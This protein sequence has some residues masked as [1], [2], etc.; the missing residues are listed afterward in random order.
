[1]AFHVLDTIFPESRSKLYAPL[2]ATSWIRKGHSQLDENLPS[3]LLVSLLILQTMSPFWKLLDRLVVRNL[4]AASQILL[5]SRSSFTKSSLT[6]RL[7]SLR[8]RSNIFLRKVGS[9]TSTGI[10]ASVPYIRLYGV[11]CVVVWGVHLYAHM[12]N[13]IFLRYKYEKVVYV[14]MLIRY[15]LFFFYFII[16]GYNYGCYSSQHNPPNY[17]FH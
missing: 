11:S 10:I 12:K 5:L 9:P 14:Y 1:V 3:F 13:D 15:C 8:V 6:E 2:A 7:S 4:H 16:Y 17:C